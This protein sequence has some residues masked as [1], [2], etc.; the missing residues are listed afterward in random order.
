MKWQ[1]KQVVLAYRLSQLS[2]N[3]GE[4]RAR[5]IREENL[6]DILAWG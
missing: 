6:F 2:K 1:K 4:V 5:L 3:G